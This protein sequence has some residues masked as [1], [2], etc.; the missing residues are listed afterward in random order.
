MLFHRGT[1]EDTESHGVLIPFYGCR[2]KKIL[3]ETLCP[4]WC[5]FF[6]GRKVTKKDAYVKD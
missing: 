6:S 1:T 4:P 5:H 3:C 2:R